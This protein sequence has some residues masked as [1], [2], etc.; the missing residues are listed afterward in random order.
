MHDLVVRGGTVFDGS[1]APPRQADVAIAGGRVVAI[2]RL[3]PGG[4]AREVDAAGALVTPGFVDIHT[5]YDL[6]VDWPGLGEHCLRQGITSVVGGNCGLGDPDPGALLARARAARLPVHLGV[7]APFG[8]LRGLVVPR[9]EGRPARPDEVPLVAAAVAQALDQGAL[10][11]SWGPYHANTLASPDELAAAVATAARRGKPLVVHRRSEG[12]HGLAATREAIALARAAGARLQISHLKA[13]GRVHWGQFEPVLEALDDA[14]RDLDVAVDVYPY[15]ASLTYLSAMLPNEL[16]AD[17][18]LLEAL[19]TRDGRARARAAVATWFSERQGPEH[20]V[21]HEPT[22]PAVPRG[23]SLLAAARALGED[24]PAEAALRLIAA[25]PRGTGGWTTYKHTMAPE[26]VEHALDLP[27]AAI[28]SD[29]VPEEDGSGLSTS[30]HPRCFSTFARALGRAARR[31]DDALARAVRQATSLPAA[32]FGLERGRLAPGAPADL[33][34]L[35]DL[36]DVA[37]HE[38]PA[39]YP[40]GVAAVVV[41]GALALVDGA[42][43]GARPGV[44]LAG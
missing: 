44:I 15:D 26:Q 34:V 3:P 28:A 19:A 41:E 35:R 18:R 7:L 1:G 25:D 5:H 8:P 2:D 13:A 43:T 14:R 23:S 11:L 36:D 9:H 38:A 31:G 4:A 33:V 12:V 40:P 10:G 22:L 30:T 37:T 17:G 42:L 32:R 6:C 29:A 39:R 16:T 27:W 20:V 21:V 24:D